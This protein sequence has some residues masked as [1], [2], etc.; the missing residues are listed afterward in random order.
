MHAVAN[1]LSAHDEKLVVF[2][3]VIAIILISCGGAMVGI[4]FRH[5]RSQL[6]LP[7]IVAHPI[8]VRVAATAQ[9][10]EL[11]SDLL[12][13]VRSHTARLGSNDAATE[14]ELPSDELID[15]SLQPRSAPGTVSE[16]PSGAQD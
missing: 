6:P 16:S 9:Y 5:H 8:A 11:D 15:D 3:A 13:A 1:L 7:S 4:Q 14:R 12:Y 2:L 10:D